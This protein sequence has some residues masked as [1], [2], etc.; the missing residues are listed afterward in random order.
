MICL[1]ARRSADLTQIETSE[2]EANKGVLIIV[3]FWEQMVGRGVI[4]AVHCEV[5]TNREQ[6]C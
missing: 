2:K 4:E 6:G 3:K 1:V 5:T